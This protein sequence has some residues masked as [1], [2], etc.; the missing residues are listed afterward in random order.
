MGAAGSGCSSSLRRAGCPQGAGAPGWAQA[1]WALLQCNQVAA[2]M[3][4]LVTS[5]QHGQVAEAEGRAITVL[6]MHGHAA[7]LLLPAA[8]AVA[9]SVAGTRAVCARRCVPSW[10]LHKYRRRLL[11]PRQPPCR[12]GWAQKWRRLRASGSS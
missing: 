8:L 3:R 4:A 9:S 10:R 6:G 2:D 7:A 11:L 1:P 12:S 5:P